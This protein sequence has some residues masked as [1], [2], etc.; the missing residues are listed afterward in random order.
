MSIPCQTYLKDGELVQG[1]MDTTAK[2]NLMTKGVDLK[3]K[4]LLDVGCNTGMMSYLASQQEALVKGIDIDCETIKQARSLYPD[5]P[6]FC[7]QA[8]AISGDYDIILASAIF[9]YT[10]L[11]KALCQFSRCTKLLI[12]DVWLHSSQVPIFAL[13]TRG[14]YIPSMPSFINIAGKYFQTIDL[15]GPSLSPDDSQRFIFHLSNPTPSIPEAVLIS[16]NGLVGK[17]TLSF[18][19]NRPILALDQIT[20]EW[21]FYRQDLLRSVRQSAA[22]VKGTHW[23]DYLEFYTSHI[24]DWLTTN[25]HRDIVIEGFDLF[26]EDKKAIVLDLLKSWKVKEINL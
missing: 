16:G 2:F 23:Q 13:T 17:S 21:F 6:F 4:R 20:H 1:T 12:C 19:F 14:L 24:S 22:I 10:D 25:K 3:H 7:E 8:E 11:E 9:H 15:K 18:T 26:D 5:I